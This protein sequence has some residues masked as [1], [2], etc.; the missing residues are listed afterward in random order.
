MDYKEWL[1]SIIEQIKAYGNDEKTDLVLL[2]NHLV[3]LVND[4]EKSPKF[5]LELSRCKD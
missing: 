1:N 5:I 4:I 2:R 3:M